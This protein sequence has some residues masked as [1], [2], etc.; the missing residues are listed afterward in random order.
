MVF[1]GRPFS[2]AQPWWFILLSG[3]VGTSAEAVAASRNAATQRREISRNELGREW[4]NVLPQGH[5]PRAS[6]GRAIANVSCYLRAFGARGVNLWV[7]P[8]LA[9]AGHD[10]IS[11]RG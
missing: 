5:R 9:H 4:L 6:L 8:G 1:W 10:A 7:E 2:M 11:A 3:V